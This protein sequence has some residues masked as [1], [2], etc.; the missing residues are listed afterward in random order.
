[1]PKVPEQQAPQFNTQFVPGVQ[2]PYRQEFGKVGKAAQELGQSV[3]RAA[4]SADYLSNRIKLA[5]AQNASANSYA[6]DK[7]DAETKQREINMQSPDGYMYDTT[8][9][10]S[11]NTVFRKDEAGRTIPIYNPDGTRQ[12]TA[13]AF[14]AWADAR[15]QATQDSLPSDMARGLYR[16]K[17]MEYFTG[18]TNSMMIEGQQKKVKAFDEQTDARVQGYQN[19]LVVNPDLNNLYRDTQDEITTQTQQVGNVHTGP[20]AGEKI[21]KIQARMAYSAIQGAW[22]QEILNKKENDPTRVQSIMKWLAVLKGEDQLSRQRLADDPR[23]PIVS[24]MMDPNQKAVEIEKLEHLLPNAKQE[25]MKGFNRLWEN[26]VALAKQNRPEGSLENGMKLMKQ[27]VQHAQNGNVIPEEAMDKISEG[28]AAVAY[29]KAS[30]NGFKIQPEEVMAGISKKSLDLILD[31]SKSQAAA[32]GLDPTYWGGVA[33]GKLESELKSM[34][35]SDIEERTK[36]LPAYVAKIDIN[37]GTSISQ[38]AAKMNTLDFS[39][40]GMLAQNAHTIQKAIQDTMAV[41]RTA[42]MPPDKITAIPADKADTLSHTLKDP[43]YSEQLAW[44]NLQNIRAGAGKFYP[45]VIQQMVAQNHLDAAWLP[46]AHISPKLDQRTAAQVISAIRTPEGAENVV[47]KNALN[48][49][50][51]TEQT[52]DKAVALKVSAWAQ[53]QTQSNPFSM[54]GAQIQAGA[55]KAIGNLAKNYYVQSGDLQ[56][57]VDKAY[58]IIIGQSTHVMDNGPAGHLWGMN[59]TGVVAIPKALANDQEAVNAIHNMSQFMTADGLAKINPMVPPGADESQRGN[60]HQ[61]VLDHRPR[62]TFQYIGG[63]PSMA[64]QYDTDKGPALLMKDAKNPWSIPLD[65]VK[66]AA[67]SGPSIMDRLKTFNPMNL[68]TLPQ[69]GHK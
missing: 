51:D 26:Y 65:Q 58:N 7:I 23:A 3:D 20:E 29:G 13:Q 61:Y 27:W 30:S 42:H 63:V 54:S 67:P 18:L 17:A 36:D 69:G 9:D 62:A 48:A 11:G 28:L 34:L 52:F 8:T 38:S 46:M 60:F 64:I 5:E 37:S 39:K 32:M 44:T 53:A 56:G 40:P 16:D 47:F 45:Q 66:K 25:D 24:N 15:Y 49:G 6:Q 21:R 55:E 31:T 59:K 12:T 50:S 41:G 43:M 10:A 68:L 57:S 2:F 1:M 14:H 19:N 22:D 4:E 35:H 33:R